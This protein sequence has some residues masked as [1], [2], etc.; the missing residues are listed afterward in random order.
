[1]SIQLERNKETGIVEAFED[2]K[3]VGEVM[4]MGD[5]IEKEESDNEDSV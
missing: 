2:G 1:M 3:K 5:Q 4:T